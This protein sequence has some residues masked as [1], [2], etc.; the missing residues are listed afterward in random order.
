LPSGDQRGYRSALPE[1][2]VRLITGP[3]SA[4][5]VNTSPRASKTARL[6]LGEGAAWPIRSATDSLRGFSV[7]RS[8]MTW[9][10][11]SLVF[12]VARFRR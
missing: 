10:A 9:I 12:C 2:R 4:G 5:T 11:T 3:N 1:L 7:V 6:P 8:V